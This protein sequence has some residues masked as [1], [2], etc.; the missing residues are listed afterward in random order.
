MQTGLL[1]FFSLAK[2]KFTEVIDIIII[3]RNTIDFFIYFPPIIFRLDRYCRSN[4]FRYAVSIFDSNW[5]WS[6][7]TAKTRNS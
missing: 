4:L 2:Q 6:K 5:S 1:S 3:K 7:T